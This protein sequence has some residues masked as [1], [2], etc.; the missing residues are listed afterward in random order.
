MIFRIVKY[1][2][3]LSIMQEE[4]KETATGQVSVENLFLASQ[5]S[6]EDAQR[7]SA[8]ENKSFSK[9]EFF[10]MDKLGTYNLRMLPIAPNQDGTQSRNNNMQRK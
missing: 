2:L 9:T 6:Y 8:E 3:N 7:Q 4:L 5:A 1:Y 10:R